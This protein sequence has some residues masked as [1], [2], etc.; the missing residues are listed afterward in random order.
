MYYRAWRPS[1]RRAARMAQAPDQN[2]TPTATRSMSFGVKFTF[3]SQ[4]IRANHA[5]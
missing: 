3:G 1:I 4:V 2:R 5:R